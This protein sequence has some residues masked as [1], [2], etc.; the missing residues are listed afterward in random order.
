MNERYRI[1]TA[2]ISASPEPLPDC[3]PPQRVNVENGHGVVALS[4]RPLADAEVEGWVRD[5]IT[6]LLWCQELEKG[7][8]GV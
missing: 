2:T 7:R 1:F 5:C 6:F 8:A 3:T 4:P